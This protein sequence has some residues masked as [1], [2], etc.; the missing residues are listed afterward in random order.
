MALKMNAALGHSIRQFR[1][2]RGMNM[3]QVCREGHLAL[4]YLSEIERGVKEPSSAVLEYIADVLE[5]PVWRI[6]YEAS[7]VMAAYE[8]EDFTA[9]VALAA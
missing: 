3:R 5:V 7:K 8:G 1:T 9:G 4:G 2:E 6:V